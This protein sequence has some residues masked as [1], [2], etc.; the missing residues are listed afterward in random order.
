M[1]IRVGGAWVIAPQRLCVFLENFSIKGTVT[2]QQVGKLLAQAR[3][4][5]HQSNE[6]FMPSLSLISDLVALGVGPVT[7]PLGSSIPPMDTK[8]VSPIH[9]PPS[10]GAFAS[11]PTRR[12]S[13]ASWN[14]A[15]K[16]QAALVLG[17][18]AHVSSIFKNKK[19]K[20][21]LVPPGKGTNQGNGRSIRPVRKLNRRE[22]VAPA[23]QKGVVIKDG[24]Q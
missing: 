20:S 2:V 14:Q 18:K 8:E 17:S 13:W 16:A 10:K 21:P 5:I 7:A 3:L 22:C 23:S 9:P 4:T 11:A 24:G 15:A 1:Q 12:A 6:V 19:F